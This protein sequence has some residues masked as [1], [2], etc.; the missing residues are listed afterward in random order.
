MIDQ[1]TLADAAW[2]AFTDSL[3]RRIDRDTIMDWMFVAPAEGDAGA[4]LRI[5]LRTG[6]GMRL[7]GP[8][9]DDGAAPEWAEVRSDRLTQIGYQAYDIA[10]TVVEIARTHW[11][12]DHPDEIAPLGDYQPDGTPPPRRLGPD[13]LRR[14]VRDDIAA[15]I[16]G[17][18]VI[19]PDFIIR[20][21]G[22]DFPTSVAVSM[23]KPQL[24]IFARVITD[25]PFDVST[26]TLTRLIGKK[27]DHITLVVRDGDLHAATFA[28][29]DGYNFLYFCWYLRRW[30]EFLDEG[31]PLLRNAL[32]IGDEPDGTPTAS[33]VARPSVDLMVA[34]AWEGYV[35]ELSAEIEALEP[36]QRL[37]V[38]QSWEYPEGPHGVVVVTASDT[39]GFTAAIDATTLHPDQECSNEQSELLFEAGWSDDGA[40]LTIGGSDAE[41]VARHIID[42]ALLATWDCVHPSFLADTTISE[43]KP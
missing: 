39:G 30:F 22:A 19:G 36:G 27:F 28:P 37:T 12:L 18:P 23:E 29:C 31:L 42:D 1:L 24:D 8:R 4:G 32:G 26:E 41:A 20:I 16:G 11:L 43:Q 10:V 7:T 13:A 6:Q 5:D 25:L 40:W 34:E 14:R 2:E 21:P 15:F 9:P 35:E 33:R 17:A 38:A 3:A